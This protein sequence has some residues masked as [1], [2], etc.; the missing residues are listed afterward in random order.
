M[1]SPGQS[2]GT[3]PLPPPAQLPPQ[4][5]NASSGPVQQV[6]LPQ[7]PG[8]K[9]IDPI[10]PAAPQSPPA[11]P[12]SIAEAEAAVSAASREYQQIR[13]EYEPYYQESFKSTQEFVRYRANKPRPGKGWEGDPRNWNAETD[14]ALYDKMIKAQNESAPRAVRTDDARARY[15]QAMKHLIDLRDQARHEEFVNRCREM[16]L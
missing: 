5:P 15:E 16:G 6:P 10:S 4:S 2:G 13:T 11:L 9:T 12:A 3:Q 7:R 8:G 14:K 1:Q